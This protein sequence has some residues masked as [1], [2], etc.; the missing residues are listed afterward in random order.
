MSPRDLASLATLSESGTAFGN[1][2]SGFSHRLEKTR[3]IFNKNA[4]S[5]DLFISF[6][7]NLGPKVDPRFQDHSWVILGPRILM[8]FGCTWYLPPPM[9]RAR[10]ALLVLA[11]SGPGRCRS[12]LT[13]EEHL[14][15][16][17]GN[18]GALDARFFSGFSVE[19]T[20]VAVNQLEYHPWVPNIHRDTVNW[21][22]R[23]QTRMFQCKGMK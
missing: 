5:D 11:T 10:S 12:C 4:E 7:R 19:T 23:C 8:D 2:R 9:A 20:E 15:G 17:P 3:D 14:W 22:H 1:F 21:C 6:Y 13:W 16:K 18:L